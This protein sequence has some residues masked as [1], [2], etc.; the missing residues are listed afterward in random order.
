MDKITIKQKAIAFDLM[1][2][3]KNSNEILYNNFKEIQKTKQ[4]DLL[5]K[6]IHLQCEN[7]LNFVLENNL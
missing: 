4:E 2:N 3:N 1:N 6:L 5:N 7:T